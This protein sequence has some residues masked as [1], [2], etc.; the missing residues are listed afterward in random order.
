MKHYLILV[1]LVLFSFT[2][3]SSTIDSIDSRF[4]FLVNNDF[5]AAEQ[6]LDSFQKAYAEDPELQALALR[7][8]TLIHFKKG[9]LDQVGIHINRIDKILKDN[10]IQDP[11][12]L[13][14]RL[15]ARNA[16]NQNRRKEALEIYTDPDIDF[17]KSPKHVQVEFLLQTA[18]TYRVM[19]SPDSA[20][21]YLEKARLIFNDYRNEMLLGDYYF[22]M[23]S[24]YKDRSDFEF[25]LLFCDSAENCYKSILYKGRLALVNVARSNILLVKNESLLARRILLKSIQFYEEIGDKRRFLRTKMS[26]ASSYS[27]ESQIDTVITIY[28]SIVPEFRSISDY[29]SMI[30]ALDNLGLKLLQKGD[31]EK[32]KYF[33]KEAI[34]NANNY[35]MPLYLLRAQLDLSECLILMRQSTEAISLLESI[36]TDI[37][38][39]KSHHML[40]FYYQLVYR[41]HELNGNYQ[42]A[43]ESIKL[44]KAYEDS[45]NEK[46]NSNRVREMEAK[47]KVNQE[48]EDKLK[49]ENDLQAKEIQNSKYKITLI[50]AVSFVIIVLIGAYVII[51]K[52]RSRNAKMKFEQE[53]LNMRIAQFRKG[54]VDK[55]NIIKQLK[56]EME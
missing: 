36:K 38:S 11:N 34:R 16:N 3:L 13:I 22:H 51:Q 27:E 56:I 26:L 43:F 42:K 31:Y 44:F 9:Q 35:D 1:S 12:H 2:I 47:M 46:S 45:L 50:S 48:R 10:N 19:S 7:N 40:S 55:L 29:A 25:A 18:Y 49:A 28:E 32:A 24:W 6:Y 8:S 5:P 52:L 23:M 39:L 41:A 20:L 15:S 17:S 4:L 33:F 53:S 21:K 37:N 54:L 30:L 14:A